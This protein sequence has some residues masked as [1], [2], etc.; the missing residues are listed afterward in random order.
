MSNKLFVLEIIDSFTNLAKQRTKLQVLKGD[1]DRTNGVSTETRK[2]MIDNISVQM[3]NLLRQYE[4]ICASVS[5]EELAVTR[6]RL[7]K[8]I[9][10]LERSAEETAKKRDWNK[11]KREACAQSTI[12]VKRYDEA[13][14]TCE[15]TL[16][17][18]KVSLDAMRYFASDLT[19]K[20]GAEMTGSTK[21][22]LK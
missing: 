6:L 22:M 4:D 17:F 21:P 11:D 19:K 2:E 3:A 13:I 9:E 15:D 7:L 14:Q 20:L 1:L 12:L 8:N 10:D 18:I 16:L 5:R